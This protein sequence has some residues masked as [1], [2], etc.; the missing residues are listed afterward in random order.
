MKQT[1]TTIWK[2][3]SHSQ[4]MKAVKKYIIAANNNEDL[5]MNKLMR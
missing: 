4:T 5:H 3:P 1:I 2:V